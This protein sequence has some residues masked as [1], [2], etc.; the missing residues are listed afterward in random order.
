MKEGLEFW[1]LGGQW[2]FSE[3]AC[4]HWQMMWLGKCKFQLITLSLFQ[5]NLLTYLRCTN[6]ALSRNNK[7]L[8]WLIRAWLDWCPLEHTIRVRYFHLHIWLLLSKILLILILLLF[9]AL[10][11]DHMN[12]FNF[13]LI[14]LYLLL[15]IVL[16]QR[17]FFI[18]YC[19]GLINL[20]ILILKCIL[21][22]LNLRLIFFLL[23]LSLF[24]HIYVILLFWRN[25]WRELWWEL[26]FILLL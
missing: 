20:L 22:W 3:K 23:I 18:I 11:S 7:I 2:R 6:A 1:I 13:R 17:R 10:F 26:S 8:F 25:F 15:L 14:I 16:N 19:L 24:K 5:N 21:C 4:I 12:I 9:L